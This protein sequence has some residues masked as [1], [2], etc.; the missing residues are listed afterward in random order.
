MYILTAQA[1]WTSSVLEVT[2]GIC[3]TVGPGGVVG[4]DGERGKDVRIG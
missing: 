4:L 2:G 1:P 3:R